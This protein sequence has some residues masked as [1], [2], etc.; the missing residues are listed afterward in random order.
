MPKID[1]AAYDAAEEMTL[2]GYKRL[3]AGGYVA[4]ITAV[5]TAWT[6]SYGGIQTAD[7]KQ[8]VKLIFD[9]AEGELA[10]M[11]SDPFWQGAE[12]DYG[13]WICLS[14]KNLGSLKSNIRA[15]EESNPGFDA[16]V[17]L[18][19]DNWQAFVGKKVGI[20]IGEQTYFGNDGEVKTRTK[21]PNLRSV[22]AIRDG[23]FKVPE[24]DTKDTDGMK[25]GDGKPAILPSAVCDDDLPF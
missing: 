11:F 19:A 22:Q 7:S 25:P 14:W 4:T 23:K 18:N 2:G 1:M 3:T 8:Y 24:L 16:M 13:H 17:A 12:K 6:D 5:R 15:I 21:L 9:I 10:G 20:V